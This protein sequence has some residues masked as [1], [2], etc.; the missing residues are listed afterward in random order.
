M[1]VILVFRSQF[2]PQP[3]V[4]PVQK[5]ELTPMAL[6]LLDRWT[7]PD[8]VFYFAKIEGDVNSINGR[9]APTLYAGRYKLT[10][11]FRA[12]WAAD[13][14]KVET[15]PLAFRLGEWPFLELEVL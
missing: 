12:D 5:P 15:E 7:F 6:S 2:E 8:I 9:L 1:N 3:Q 14:A 4:V 11:V 13:V 10:R